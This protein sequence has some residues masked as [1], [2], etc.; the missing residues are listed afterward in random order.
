MRRKIMLNRNTDASDKEIGNVVRD[1][2]SQPVETGKTNVSEIAENTTTNLEPLIV[3]SLV[4]STPSIHS[5]INIINNDTKEDNNL[6]TP[7]IN[8]T[9]QARN[10]TAILEAEDLPI[11]SPSILFEWHTKSE[12][13]VYEAMYT[14]I[15]LY[16]CIERYFTLQWLVRKTNIRSQNT[17]RT[18]LQGLIKKKSI[19]AIE[20]KIGEKIGNRY[21]VYSPSAILVRRKEHSVKIDSQTKKII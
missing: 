6:N 14:E 11:L 3:T 20:S 15:L 12:Q 9:I 8:E 2:L 7:S 5:T 4:S 21:R 18:A 10:Q 1:M 13:K 19:D 17:I 16:Q